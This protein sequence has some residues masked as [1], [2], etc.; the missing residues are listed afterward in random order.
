MYSMKVMSMHTLILGTPSE[1]Q[2]M[3]S[4]RTNNTNLQESLNFHRDLVVTPK[5]GFK[6]AIVCKDNY[7]VG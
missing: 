7:R 2:E 6:F 4:Q 3:H 5:V 1:M